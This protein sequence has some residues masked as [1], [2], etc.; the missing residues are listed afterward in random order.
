MKVLSCAARPPLYFLVPV[1]MTC[2]VV[3][4]RTVFFLY[5]MCVFVTQSDPQAVFFWFRMRRICP[6]TGRITVP[7]DQWK[8]CF[9][10]ITG[11]VGLLAGRQSDKCTHKHYGPHKYVMLWWCLACTSLW[12]MT[13]VSFTF[14]L[15]FQRCA[16]LWT[17]FRWAVAGTKQLRLSPNCTQARSL[18]C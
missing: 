14:F 17:L 8:A 13:V 6:I 16:P 3:D 11:P 4:S 2:I 10:L 7:W 9:P 5:V 15:A 12:V 1:L 18:S